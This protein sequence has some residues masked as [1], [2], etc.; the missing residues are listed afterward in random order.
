MGTAGRLKID[1]PAGGWRL[2]AGGRNGSRRGG[3]LHGRAGKRTDADASAFSGLEAAQLFGLFLAGRQGSCVLVSECCDPRVQGLEICVRIRLELALS[4]APFL[5]DRVDR[6][7]FHSRPPHACVDHGFYAGSANDRR[8]RERPEAPGT[9]LRALEVHGAPD[10]CR[11]PGDR[12]PSRARTPASRESPRIVIAHAT[13]P[14]SSTGHRN[15]RRPL[16]DAPPGVGAVRGPHGSEV[17]RPAALGRLT[18]RDSVQM[19]AI[20]YGFSSSSDARDGSENRP[21]RLRR[22][23]QSEERVGG[24][25]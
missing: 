17:G 14:L 2:L 19:L 11:L 6:P 18:Y 25:A 20:V 3:P 15:A 9:R 21:T 23:A 1:R 22:R 16:G 13:A 12:G 5:E 10:G 8:M 4:F 24:S 7:R